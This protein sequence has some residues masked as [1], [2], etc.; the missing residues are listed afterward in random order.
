MKINLKKK[1]SAAQLKKELAEAEEFEK[2]KEEQAKPAPQINTLK[3]P[4][5]PKPEEQPTE[6]Q[7]T[8][9]EEPEPLTEEELEKIQANIAYFRRNYLG[10]YAPADMGCSEAEATICSLLF[11]VLTELKKINDAFDKD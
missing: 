5:P 1:K 4:E 10:I 6:P 3:V 2:L 8:T 9:Q 11:G 7:E